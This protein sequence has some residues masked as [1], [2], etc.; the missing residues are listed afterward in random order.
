MKYAV[1][2][3]S[4]AGKTTLIDIILGLLIPIKEVRIQAIE[5]NIFVKDI[6]SFIYKF[7]LFFWYS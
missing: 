7:Q 2:G 5:E 3:E 4:G 6:R 1:L